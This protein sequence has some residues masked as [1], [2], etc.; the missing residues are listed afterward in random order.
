ML[1]GVSVRPESIRGSEE[2]IVVPL[3]AGTRGPGGAAGR[4]D[5]SVRGAIAEAIR[6]GRFGGSRREMFLVTVRQSKRPSHLLLL[7]LGDSAPFDPENVADAAGACARVLSGHKFRSAWLLFPDEHGDDSATFAHAFVK[8]F[9]LALYGYRMA[10]EPRKPS[11]LKRLT[12]LAAEDRKEIGAAARRALIVAEQVAAVRDFVNAPAAEL[13][14]TIFARQARSMCRENGV[15]CRVLGEK[16]LEKEKMGAMLAVGRGSV[17]PSRLIVMHYNKGKRGVPRVC[18]VGKGVT[19][20]SGGISIKPWNG[21]WEMKGDMAGAAVAVSSINAAARLGLPLEIVAIA[22]CVENMPDGRAVKPGDVV[23]T[24][25]G[26]T[27]EVLSTDAEGRL[28]LVDAITYARKHFE[29]DVLIDYATLTGAVLIALGK[30]IAG[31]MGNSQEHIDAL[32]AAGREAG[33]P[34]WQLPLD[35][36]HYEAVKGDISDYKNYAGRDASTITAAALLG[37]FVGKTPWAHLDIA[38]TFWNDGSG[39]RYQT[40]GAT[41]YGVDLTLRFLEQLAG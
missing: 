4:L 11:P 3:T 28:I 36:H 9:A 2:V 31:I 5:K 21:M 15:T 27:I 32:V 13:T 26:S 19:F 40:K 6:K 17:E 35:G 38:G 14:P 25:E 18:L 41:G 7:G 30:R 23:T 12:I 37:S 29:P 10:K 8:G 33:E 24:A 20:D 16:E 39:P 34:L 22:P 1:K